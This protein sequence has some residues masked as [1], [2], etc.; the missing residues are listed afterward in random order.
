MQ[1]AN[2]EDEYGLLAKVF[3]WLIAVLIIGLLPMGLFMSGMENS[4]LKFEIFALHKSFGLLVF[5][6]GLARVVWRRRTILKITNIG[7]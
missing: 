6:L 1:L 2:T 5:F 7:K 3:H 4:P